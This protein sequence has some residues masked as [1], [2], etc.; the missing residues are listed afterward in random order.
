MVCEILFSFKNAKFLNNQLG[1]Y[2]SLT[3]DSES[4]FAYLAPQHNWIVI[5]NKT[6]VWWLPQIDF[7]A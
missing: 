3:D 6:R 2:A 4:D 1:H 7:I 5:I